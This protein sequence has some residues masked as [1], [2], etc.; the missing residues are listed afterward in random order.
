MSDLPTRRLASTV[1]C[2]AVLT[3][4]TGPAAMAVEASPETGRAVSR[5][6]DPAAER[7]KL[8]AQ[9]KALGLTGSVLQPVAGLLN[10]SLEE[11]TLSAGEAARLGDAAKKAI[12]EAAAHPKPGVST[13][14]ALPDTGTSPVPLLVPSTQAT[15]S[16]APTATAS[17]AT[18]T[19][20][21]VS[22]VAPSVP[23]VP[24]AMTA[25]RAAR[26][27]DD[28][29]RATTARDLTDDI[30]GALEAA[31]D[32]LVKSVTGSLD[33]LLSSANDVVSGLV[34]L[35]N[36]TLP[37]NGLPAAGLPAS[38]SLPGLPDVSTLPSPA[39]LPDVSTL[40]GL[41]TLP[42]ESSTSNVS[43]VANVPATD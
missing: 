8:L 2:V 4:V 43:V 33:E 16:S 10:R 35:L 27:I 20:G 42:D 28:G 39:G 21:A 5:A 7:E 30:L 29:K 32:D 38:P 12:A 23:S 1:L 22:A 41:V 18:S 14:Q 34:D 17:A 36:T 26:H 37:G 13:A 11:G 6:T 25:Q 19:T 40:P 3:G 24:A 31:I 15:P 9:V